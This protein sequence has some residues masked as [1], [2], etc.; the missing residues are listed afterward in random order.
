MADEKPAHKTTQSAE[1]RI[2]ALEAALADSQALVPT[3]LV[4]EH[5]AG[6]GMEVRDT[7]SQFEQERAFRID[8][9]P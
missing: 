7:W 9:R 1:D 4:P 6:P 8:N 2:A 5:G 3:S